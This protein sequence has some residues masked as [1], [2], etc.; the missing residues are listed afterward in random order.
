MSGTTKNRREYLFLYDVSFANPNGDPNDENKPRID[1][2]TGRNIVTD[3]R[4]KR[5]IRDYLKDFEGQEIF[6]REISDEEGNI[7]DAKARA[8]D[9]ENNPERILNECIDVRLFGGTIPI[10]TGKKKDSSI[11]YTG[12]VQ[13]NMGQSLHRVKL[14]FIKGTGAF[15]SKEGQQQKTFREE[16]IL[17]YSFIAFHG[18]VNENAAKDTGLT[19]E[20]L[21]YLRKAM[22]EGTKNLLTRSKNE[23]MP[24]LLIEIVYKDGVHSH[25]GEL[26]R[27]IRIESDKN[28]EELRSTDDFILNIDKLLEVLEEEAD[29][30]E[31]VLYKKDRNLRLSKDLISDKAQFEEMSF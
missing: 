9:F 21:A 22:W 6:V 13:F 30:I 1:E 19:D 20:D 29:K 11:T 8:K 5:T 17:P 16:W 18:V 31:K 24:R 26:H 7:Q 3:V 10:E 12:P 2:E 25:I 23:Q 15:A 4:L 27:Y 28:D 14:E